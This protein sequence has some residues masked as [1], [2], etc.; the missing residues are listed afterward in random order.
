MSRKKKKTK[1]VPWLVRSKKPTQGKVRIDDHLE[2]PGLG[3]VTRMGKLVV[4][5]SQRTPIEQDKLTRHLAAAHGDVV[6]KIQMHVDELSRVIPL[7]KPLELLHLAY[8]DFLTNSLT[9]EGEQD[10]D[11][12]RI[13][14]LRALDY[15]QSII[16]SRTPSPNYSELTETAWSSIRQHIFELYQVLLTE[17]PSTYSAHR[18]IQPGYSAEDDDDAFRIPL[19][20]EWLA[21]RGARYPTHE[22]ERS[23]AL[24]GAHDVT[25]HEL[26]GVSAQKTSEALE[27]ILYRLTKGVGEAIHTIA[28]IHQQTLSDEN[29]S[30]VEFG[31]GDGDEAESEKEVLSQ[32]LDNTGRRDEL[33]QAYGKLLGPSLFDVTDLLPENLLQRISLSPGQD[34][35]FFAS[36]SYS[37]WPV[38]TPPTH[39]RPVISSNGRF[40]VFNPYSMDNFYRAIELAV[41][42]EAPNARQR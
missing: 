35:E 17:W 29:I 33:A 10:V 15:I 37:G 41:M 30:L 1:K 24:L 39:R 12:A 38:R 40:Y 28:E 11:F 26:F 19:L 4:T 7:Y 14:D 42:E 3:T 27:T 20:I 18:R 21:V 9:I 16:V 32:L 36:G 31:C 8:K 25:L 22:G 2:I 6:N 23:R 34:V 13:I 5:E